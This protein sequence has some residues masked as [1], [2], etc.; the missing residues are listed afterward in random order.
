MHEAFADAVEDFAKAE[1]TV[2]ERLR[3]HRSDRL[4]PTEFD[5]RR[6]FLGELPTAFSAALGQRQHES[7]AP[8]P[9]GAADSVRRALVTAA[10]QEIGSRTLP[11]DTHAPPMFTAIFE[12]TGVP[13][14]W[15]D[16]FIREAAARLKDKHK[17]DFEAIRNAEQL[18]YV[19]NR[20]AQRDRMLAIPLY[21][22]A[23]SD[24]EIASIV[25]RRPND[26]LLARH[27]IVP[28]LDH[29]GAPADAR[30]WARVPAGGCRGPP[31]RRIRRTRQDAHGDRAGAG[32]GI[33]DNG[34]AGPLVVIDHAE[35]QG[36]LLERVAR[37]ALRARLLMTLEEPLWVDFCRSASRCGSA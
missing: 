4:T 20:V 33:G 6:A 35:S 37:A 23:A 34:A 17:S 5:I 8:R 30:I 36:A 19:R 1:W 13:E 9:A 29:H 31:L 27:R 2:A 18:A 3:F 16:L 10:L 14:S 21:S 24:R 22:G 12:G 25:T 15:F 26:L 7:G 11:E 28:F 32:A